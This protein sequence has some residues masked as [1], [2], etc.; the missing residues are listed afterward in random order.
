VHAIAVD[1]YVP[2]AGWHLKTIDEAPVVESPEATARWQ[3]PTAT[4]SKNFAL[5]ELVSGR[6]CKRRFPITGQAGSR[7]TNKGSLTL[8][9][10]A[11]GCWPVM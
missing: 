10:H 3:I 5:R 4:D 7:K 8:P 2:V 9:I 1:E 11:S 6:V